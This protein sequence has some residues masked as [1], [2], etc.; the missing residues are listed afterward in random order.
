MLRKEGKYMNILRTITLLTS[1]LL[2]AVSV[3][4]I[5]LVVDS[6]QKYGW[7]WEVTTIINEQNEMRVETISSQI[8]IVAF[9]WFLTIV[10][11]ANYVNLR[12]H[13]PTILGEK[14]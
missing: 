14:P 3:T 2:L 13:S 4:S 12:K 8:L 11:M 6:Y 9:L 5:W 7:S 1:I 10:T